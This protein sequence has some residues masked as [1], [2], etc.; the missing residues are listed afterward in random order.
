MKKDF[1]YP[2]ASWAKTDAWP[3]YIGG[4]DLATTLCSPTQQ[5]TSIGPAQ[6]GARPTHA[7]TPPRRILS[8]GMR[9]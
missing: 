3:S 8:R 9:S 4:A 7:V 6:G 5:P 2:S 1:L